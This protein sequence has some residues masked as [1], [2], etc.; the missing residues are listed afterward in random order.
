M[1]KIFQNVSFFLVQTERD[2]TSLMN[3][4][5]N[6]AKVAVGGNLKAEIDLPVFSDAA[7]VELRGSLGIDERQKIVVAGS[8]R[9][10]EEEQLLNSFARAKGERK[11]I[12]L[13]LA[14]RHVERTGEVEKLCEKLDLEAQRRTTVHPDDRWDVLILDTLGE[15]VQFY[16]ISDVSFVGG[17]LIPWGGQNLLEPAFYSKPVFFGPH[18]DNF[19]HLARSFLDADSARILRKDADLEKMFLFEDEQELTLLGCRAKETLDAL[20]GAT[21][22]TLALIEKFLDT[23]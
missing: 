3:A 1:Q 19:A 7:L 14:P 21:D 5:V 11:D 15:L 13:I 4:G 22:K 8:T 23:K 2:K 16:A 20:S 6:A 9:K 10:G 12:R 17:S 18:M